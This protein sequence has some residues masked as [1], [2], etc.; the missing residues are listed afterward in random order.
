MSNSLDSGVRE[1]LADAGSTADV[2]SKPSSPHHSVVDPRDRSAIILLYTNQQ[3]GCAAPNE[4]GKYIDDILHHWI[5]LSNTCFSRLERRHGYIQW[6]FPTVKRS[7]NNTFAPSLTAADIDAFHK[8]DSM[9]ARLL[10]AYVMML[11]FFG[12]DIEAGTGRL[13]RLNGHYQDRF[14]NLC[15]KRHNYLRITRIMDSLTTLI[16]PDGKKYARDLYSFIKNEEYLEPMMRAPNDCDT[17]W[18]TILF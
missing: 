5:E 10:E 8:S 16:V 14:E 3:I 6:L 15:T 11:H 7:V 9:R 4:S 13:V 1:K 12:I 17:Y 2:I 18:R